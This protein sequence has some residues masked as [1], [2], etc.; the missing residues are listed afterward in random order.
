MRDKVLVVGMDGL[1]FDRVTALRPPTLT[2]LISTGAHGTSLLPYGKPA[3][4]R[5]QAP[6]EVIRTPGPATSSGI[7]PGVAVRASGECDREID[8]RTDS[9][10]GWASILTGVWP[11]RHRVVDNGFGGARFTKYPDFLTRAKQARPE[12]NTSAF[13]SWA[14]LDEHGAFGLAVDSRFVLDGYAISFMTADKQLAAAA[15]SHLAEADPDLMFVYLGATDEVAHEQG[16]LCQEYADALMAQ[17][18]YLGRFVEAVR[19]RPPYQ[20]ERWTVIVTTDHGHV[21]GGG[22]GGDS[23]EERGVFMI[24]AR[25][26]EDL[27][28]IRLD[29]PRLVDVGPTAL[30]QLGIATD[31]GWDLDGIPLFISR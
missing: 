2:H 1:R 31:P 21:D 5:T 23:A 17:D 30:A 10:P 8:S 14:A 25:L 18:S 13:F 6:G 15:E 22:H 29:G 7:G 11:D 9:G 12:L 4:P 16:P 26:E 24:A 28:G 27:G 3:T 19:S 20:E